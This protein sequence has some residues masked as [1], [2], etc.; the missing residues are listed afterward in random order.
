M[1]VGSG[2]GV[3]DG[4]TAA[5]VAPGSAAVERSAGDPPDELIAARASA[6]ATPPASSCR[7]LKW[8][9]VR[10]GST[11]VAGATTQL[12]TVGA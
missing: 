10:P 7:P 2:V 3:D 1:R 12:D 8:R 4:K 11:V 5:G 9:V 6:I